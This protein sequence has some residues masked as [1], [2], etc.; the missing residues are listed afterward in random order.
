[1]S[2]GNQL[3]PNNS[4]WAPTDRNQLS[5]TREITPTNL[6]RNSSRGGGVVKR[7]SLES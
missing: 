6:A 7:T 1:M 2:I 3:V 4:G 5:L